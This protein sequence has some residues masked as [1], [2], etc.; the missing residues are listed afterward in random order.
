MNT[1]T[2]GTVIQ[3]FCP[4]KGVYCAHSNGSGCSLTVPCYIGNV[5]GDVTWSGSQKP[6]ENAMPIDR[7]IELLKR[8]YW[9]ENDDLKMA[10][11]IAATILEDIR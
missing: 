3:A 6:A 10:K 7:V 4:A 8:D 9:F 2:T 1:T 11:Q 5:T